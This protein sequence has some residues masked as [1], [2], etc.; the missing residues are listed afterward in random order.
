MCLP[1]SYLSV[2][3]V[4]PETVLINISQRLNKLHLSRFMN[5]LLLSL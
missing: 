5:S 3:M 2:E 1:C 4:K